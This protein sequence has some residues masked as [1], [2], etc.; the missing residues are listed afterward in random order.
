MRPHQAVLIEIAFGRV[1]HIP[2]RYWTSLYGRPTPVTDSVRC[3]HFVV[4][5]N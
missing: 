5:C 4:D 2:D 3:E 1:D